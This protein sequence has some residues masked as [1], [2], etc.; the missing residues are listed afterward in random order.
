MIRLIS[1]NKNLERDNGW[2]II[3]KRIKDKFF[4]M[5]S[6]IKNMK[7]RNKL[8][9]NYIIFGIFPFIGIGIFGTYYIQQLMFEQEVTRNKDYLNQAVSGLVD[10]LKVYNN[11]NDYLSFSAPVSRICADEY[12]SEYEKYRDYSDGFHSLIGSMK[13][14]H[15]EIKR[16]TLYLD[17]NVVSFQ[18]TIMPLDTIKKEQWYVDLKKDNQIYWLLLKERKKAISIRTIP[19]LTKEKEYHMLYMELEYHTLFERFQNITDTDYG[20]F[21]VNDKEE[22]LYHTEHF[23]KE[24]QKIGLTFLQMKEQEK[25]QENYIVTSQKVQNGNWNIYLYRSAKGIRDKI[26]KLLKTVLIGIVFIGIIS[27]LFIR[28]VTNKVLKGIENLRQNMRYVEE[29]ELEIQIQKESNDEIGE[30]IQ[31]FQSM[32]SKIKILVEEVYEGKL[33]QKEYEMRALQ[34]QI[35]PHFLYNSLSLI[36]WMALETDQEEISNITLAMSSFYRTALNRGNNIILLKDEIENMKSYLAIQLVMHD[37][38]FDV[39]ISMQEEVAYCEVLNLILQPI[40]EN[41]I[42]HGI[43]LK[44][45]GRGKIQVIA[46]EEEEHIVLIVKDNGVGMEQ[47]KAD[48][49]LTTKSKGYGIYNVNERIKLFYGEEYSIHIESKVGVGTTMTIQ[50][51]KKKNSLKK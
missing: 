13:Y 28:L 15:D 50:L 37:Y 31:G 42:E 8:L 51:P 20:V 5:T 6:Y 34:A 17:R 41:S 35:N 48:T 9:F 1:N 3:L 25:I 23:S 27:F 16:I 11:L 30:L 14:F 2:V 12:V 45:D 10:Q 7:L 32:I 18:D 39:D 33:R 29:G 40:V 47:E 38:E 26:T 22:V 49:I 36:N 43:D 44:T 4:K 21:V 46:K 24:S 19:T